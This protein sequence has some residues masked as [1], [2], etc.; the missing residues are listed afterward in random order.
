MTNTRL[1]KAAMARAGMTAGEVAEAIKISRQS[2]SYKVNNIREFTV[3]EIMA[4][5][6]VLGLTVEEKEA[7]FFSKQVDE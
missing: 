7:I 5:S 3:S 4:I 1:L 2:Y 6:D